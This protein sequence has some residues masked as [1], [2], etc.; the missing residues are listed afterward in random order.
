MFLAEIRPVA[1]ALLGSKTKRKD[2]V[3]E[4]PI[5]GFS[6]TMSDESWRDV[7]AKGILIHLRT[8]VDRILS[9]V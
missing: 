8:F 4:L 7:S 1:S 6:D 3:R 5:E 2:S 9:A